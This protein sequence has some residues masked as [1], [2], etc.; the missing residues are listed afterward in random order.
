M[1]GVAA[2]FLMQRKDD[3]ELAL[4]SD[5][6]AASAEGH[7]VIK[8]SGKDKGVEESRREQA[9]GLA[10]HRSVPEPNGSHGGND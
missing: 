1:L 6:R 7:G 10:C 9:A 8:V 4:G 2:Y 5:L 3:T